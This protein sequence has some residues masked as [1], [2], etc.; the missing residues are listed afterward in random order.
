MEKLKV[1]RRTR[2]RQ[3]TVIINEATTA[4]QDAGVEQLSAILQRL[5]VNN[6][7]LRKI[8]EAIEDGLPED[9]FEEEYV[10]TIEYDDRANQAIGLLKAKIAALQASNTANSV[11]TS[12]PQPPAQPRQQGLKLPKL[13]LEPFN[14]E[15][16][17]W[18]AFWE[19]FQKTVHDNKE[20]SKAEKFQYL[21]S[22]LTGTSMTAVRGLQATEACYEDAVEILK[23]R[24]GN[25]EKIEQE[26][27]A[28]LRTLPSVASSEDVRGLRR[29]YDHVQAHIRGLK[30]LGMSMSSYSAMLSGVLLSE[31]PKEMVVDF[32]RELSRTNIA[33]PPTLQSPPESAASSASGADSRLSEILDFLLVEIES[34]ERC[35]E[36]ARATKPP[37]VPHGGAKRRKDY[38]LNTFGMTAAKTESF[39]IV[40]L[41]LRSQ[42]SDTETIIEA[43]EVPFI[44]KDVVPVPVDHAFVQEIEVKGG[45]IADKLIYPGMPA[46]QGIALLIGADHLWKFLSG[47]VL[48]STEN[49]GLAAIETKFGWTFQGPLSIDSSL[50][51]ATNVCILKIGL[52]SDI[53]QQAILEKFWELDAIGVTNEEG[54]KQEESSFTLA[55]IERKGDRYEV[56]LPWKE[57]ATELGDNKDMAVKRLKSLTKRLCSSKELAE[58]YDTAIRS[59]MNEGHAE[60]VENETA[61]GHVYYMPHQPVIRTQSKTTKLRVV[62]DAS[63][64][65]PEKSSLN[66]HLEK[67]PKLISDMVR[68][69]LRFRLH[70]VALVADIEKAFLQI[71]V[72]PQDRDA[73]RF[74][75][76]SE[77]PLN[78]DALPDVEE[79]RMQ[80][81][82]FGTTASPYL[83]NAVLLRH[84]E[85]QG[86]GLQETA[87]VLR[88]SFYVDDLVTGAST[89]DEALK[90]AA[91]AQKI[92][93]DAGMHLR[94][95]SSNS[96]K[97]R[98]ALSDQRSSVPEEP[99]KM[100]SLLW[101]PSTDEMSIS[102]AA[103]LISVCTGVSTKRAVLQASARIFDPLGRDAQDYCSTQRITWKFIIEKAAWWGGWWERM[104][105]SVKVSL[106]KILGRQ[107]LSFEELTTV[108][109]DVEATI[110]SRPL[111]YALEEP[112]ERIPK[113]SMPACGV[114]LARCFLPRYMGSGCTEL[115]TLRGPLEPPGLLESTVFL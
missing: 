110:N 10:E 40:E 108:L 99:Q 59:Y 46:V 7:E 26:H 32:H 78:P 1:K 95:W 19:C 29:L 23:R 102:T 64:H 113:S 65:A 74:L 58:E 45:P 12:Q 4:L 15:L 42:Y 85:N 73:L 53:K 60:R 11:T 106:R 77:A 83:L 48:R 9:T 81:V 56:S 18:G 50:T 33:E 49:N 41:R 3:N 94:K 86:V 16:S 39:R 38:H 28:Q 76:Y 100:L 62:F 21:R 47:Q 44:C 30:G 43:V 37:K 52:E 82:P 31:L 8:N 98:M 54:M 14:G 20:L 87:A 63:S 24:F 101:T 84:L 109:A 80:R 91:E 103:V 22:L 75:W 27:L 69:L 89:A 36:G 6:G 112:G 61:S 90:I 114:P 79:W 55:S 72:R 5:E 35:T 17:A 93:T 68:I 67:G 104:V 107:S 57:P 71:I 96:E 2:R 13:R 92:M 70:P 25:K 51:M 105:R 34:R 88:D 66:E 111:T 97:V 115:V